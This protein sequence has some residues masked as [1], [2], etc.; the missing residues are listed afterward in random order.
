MRL[1]RL[2]TIHFKNFDKYIYKFSTI[3]ITLLLFIN[4]ILM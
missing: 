3:F 2:T 4:I 1:L